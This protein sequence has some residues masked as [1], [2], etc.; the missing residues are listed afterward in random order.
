MLFISSFIVSLA[1]FGR[2]PNL[3]KMDTGLPAQEEASVFA[4]G[5]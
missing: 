4:D 1:C 5:R 3:D 2:L